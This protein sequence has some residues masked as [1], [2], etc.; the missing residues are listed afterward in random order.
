M[1]T[2]TFTEFRKNASAYLSGVEQ[3]E[4]L[5]VYRHGKLIAEIRPPAAS[6]HIREEPS[7]KGPGKR[8]K[9]KGKGLSELIL[10]ERD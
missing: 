5:L 9:L 3:G 8:L 4:T 1:K 7:W 6:G 10:E 2:V